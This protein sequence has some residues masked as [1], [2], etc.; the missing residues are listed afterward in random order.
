MMNPML[1]TTMPSTVIPMI[2][3]AFTVTDTDV[4]EFQRHGFRKLQK[5]F[6]PDLV[7]YMRSLAGGQ[8]TPPSGNYGSGFSKLK[9]D[10]GNDDP[11]ILSLMSDATFGAAMSKLTEIQPFF[12][13]G[14]GFELAKN[15]STGFPWH[16][17]TQSFGFQ[18]RQD[19]GFTI[20]TPLCE[21]DPHG[22]RGGMAYV[23]KELL[24][25]EFVYQHINLLPEY[26]RSLI[27]GGQEL[28]YSDFEALKNNLLNSHG[29]N[30]VLN[31]YAVEDAFEPGDALIFDKYVL[32]RSVRLEEG[33]IPSRLAYALRFCSVDARYDLARVRALAFPR[34]TFDYDVDSAFNE[35]VGQVDGEE[36]YRSA[37]F[38]GSREA[39]TLGPAPTA[40]ET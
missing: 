29:M 35:E 38:D 8:V 33:P 23:S 6:S 25:G 40:C 34:V 3:P 20:W 24:S 32:H 2:D 26:M 4:N 17:G 15:T 13:Q 18:R 27:A 16:V 10:I 39:R 21:I 37:Y 11:G 7:E 36:V 5:I 14:L 9:Y 1:D 28:T 30:D 19:A 31:H 22:Q 12:T